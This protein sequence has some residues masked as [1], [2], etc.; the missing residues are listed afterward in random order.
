VLVVAIIIHSIVDVG[1]GFCVGVGWMLLTPSYCNTIGCTLI[2]FCYPYCCCHYSWCS[3]CCNTIRLLQL[4]PVHQHHN[5]VHRH[6]PHLLL[7]LLK[8]GITTTTIITTNDDED[9]NNDYGSRIK[10]KW[11]RSSSSGYTNN[12]NNTQY[13]PPEHPIYCEIRWLIM[14]CAS[15]QMTPITTICTFRTVVVQNQK[16]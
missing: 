10:S 2:D 1:V 3:C 15:W 9:D 8:H 6:H 13:I 16:K 12:N 7:F 5:F 4:L 14:S 11:C